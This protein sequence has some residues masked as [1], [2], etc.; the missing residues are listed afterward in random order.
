[1]SDPIL[2]PTP[3]TVHVGD[4]VAILLYDQT[5]P[6]WR[7]GTVRTLERTRTDE[8]Q[9]GV[10]SAAVTTQHPYIAEVLVEDTDTTYWATGR[11]LVALPPP[12]DEDIDADCAWGAIS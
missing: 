4:T 6:G 7:L 5:P 2:R 10:P 12:T 8:D 9:L 3:T 11:R 1:M